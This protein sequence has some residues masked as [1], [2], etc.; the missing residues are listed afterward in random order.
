M[1]VSIC[2]CMCVMYTC[3]F[4]RNDTYNLFV[5]FLDAVCMYKYVHMGSYKYV[6]MDSYKYV[7]MDSS[8]IHHPKKFNKSLIIGFLIPVGMRAYVYMQARICHPKLVDTQSLYSFSQRC[9]CMCMSVHVHLCGLC[10]AQIYD[11]KTY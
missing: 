6:H 8:S 7:H 9:M 4:N 3:F 10:I 1:Y 2:M 11:P 5:H